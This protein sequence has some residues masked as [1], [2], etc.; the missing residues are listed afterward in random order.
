MTNDENKRNLCYITILGFIIFTIIII[1][2]I[3]NLATR[4]NDLELFQNACYNDT[5]GYCIFRQQNDACVKYI[6]YCYQHKSECCEF[7]LKTLEKNDGYVLS[8][9]TVIIV[10][11]GS[12][13]YIITIVV[14]LILM[15]KNKKKMNKNNSQ[16]LLFIRKGQ[17]RGNESKYS[18]ISNTII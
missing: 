15:S 18:S 5:L 10:I 4:N 2:I 16:P 3:I 12:I 11:T 1:V 14:I 7:V 13:I 9:P 17:S 8:T 6:P